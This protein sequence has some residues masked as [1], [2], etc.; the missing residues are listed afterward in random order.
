M[1]AMKDLLQPLKG[2]R[3]LPWIALVILVCAAALLLFRDTGEIESVTPGTDS[4]A[5]VEAVLSRVEGAG[6]V[7]V[8]LREKTGSVAAFS[9]SASSALPEVEG[10]VVVSE[11]ADNIRVQLAL[12][13]AV[14][15][16]LGVPMERIEVLKM[17]RSGGT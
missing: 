1:K 2:A 15:A 7:Q 5:R 14:R 8:L 17:E 10:V 11:G 6:R 3:G 13:R 16:L 12:T 4:E 9:Q